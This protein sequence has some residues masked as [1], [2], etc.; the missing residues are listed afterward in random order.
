MKNEKSLEEVREWKKKIFEKDKGVSTEA[1][2]QRIK[3]ET[4]ELKQH[5]NLPAYQSRGRQLKV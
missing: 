4:E 5:L 1:L 2:I 3:S